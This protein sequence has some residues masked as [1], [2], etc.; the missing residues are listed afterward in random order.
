MGKSLEGSSSFQ[1]SYCVDRH[2]SHN[3]DPGGPKDFPMKEQ[4][5][6]HLD[7]NRNEYLDYTTIKPNE[8]FSNC[9]EDSEIQ[10]EESSIDNNSNSTEKTGPEGDVLLEIIKD[11]YDFIL[12]EGH[13]LNNGNVSDIVHD[14]Q[15]YGSTSH[16]F[17]LIRRI[18]EFQCEQHRQLDLLGQIDTSEL[19]R[20]V[21]Q[22]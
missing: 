5:E 20:E 17:P 1:P 2:Q 13:D 7:N 16:S 6:G 10:L 21:R 3:I 4:E 14:N 15:L 22:L 18:A 9:Q 12:K 8:I 19:P 11:Q